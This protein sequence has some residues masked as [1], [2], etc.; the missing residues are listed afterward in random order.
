MSETGTSLRF[1][2][3]I[4][5]GEEILHPRTR[6][7]AYQ[8]D[9]TVRHVLRAVEAFVW[10]CPAAEQSGTLEAD[11]EEAGFSEPVTGRVSTALHVSGN[12]IPLLH[13]IMH[14]VWYVSLSGRVFRAVSAQWQEP[15]PPWPWRI[16]PWRDRVGLQALLGAIVNLWPRDN[17]TML[18]Q[19]F[20]EPLRVVSIYAE[21]QENQYGI[22][23]SR[24]LELLPTDKLAA[25]WPLRE[26]AAMSP[27]TPITQ[28]SMSDA[29][30]P[31]FVLW[32]PA[33]LK[34]PSVS[35]LSM[36]D[37][38][39]EQDLPLPVWRLAAEGLR[40]ENFRIVLPDAG[41]TDP[42]VWDDNLGITGGKF[43]SRA[44]YPF[45]RVC[46]DMGR[47]NVPVARNKRCIEHLTVKDPTPPPAGAAHVR[48]S[49][50]TRVVESLRD[51]VPSPFNF[52]GLSRPE[53]QGDS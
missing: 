39:S 40:Y 21:T 27:A 42:H 19:R 45:C 51:G 28:H 53:P 3:L 5:E 14:D 29:L 8:N 23:L 1:L 18:W 6:L 7:L 49:T 44:A 37:G 2:R 20:S 47:F 16:V 32:A 48:R 22:G 38:I 4:L 52:P 30:R 50:P 17:G 9:S 11:W 24:A 25:N 35:L 41:G 46:E 36:L 12:Q 15:A 26:V 10:V 43:R 33:N 13:D 31:E 34:T